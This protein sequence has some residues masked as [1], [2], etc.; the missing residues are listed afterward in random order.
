MIIYKKDINNSCCKID[1]LRLALIGAFLT[2]VGDFLA[3]L[4]VFADMQEAC[5][6][7]NLSSENIINKVYAENKIKDLEKEIS[8]LKKQINY[9]DS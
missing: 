3:F 9:T 7:T 1:P 8:I 5:Q 4:A 6:N 2:L